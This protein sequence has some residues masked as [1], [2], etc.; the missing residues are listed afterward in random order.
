MAFYK[1]KFL[2]D[3]IVVKEDDVFMQGLNA[4]K[5]SASATAR[6]HPAMTIEIFDIGDKRLARKEKGQWRDIDNDE[7]KSFG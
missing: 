1:I 5:V 6:E 7:A 3:G 4:A 2:V